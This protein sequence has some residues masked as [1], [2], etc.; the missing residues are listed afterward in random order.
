MS[1][2]VLRLGLLLCMCL[3][4]LLGAVP[5][6]AQPAGIEVQS[7]VDHEVVSVGDTVQ[8]TLQVMSTGSGRE[9]E[10]PQ[11][12]TTQGFTVVGQRASPSTS[13]SII[14]GVRS[15]KT[16]LSVTWV[17]RAEREG[18][19]TL[20]P[21][22]V[23]SHG[24]R[25]SGTVLS[26]RV[27]RRGAA[28]GPKRPGPGWPFA[29]GADP[30]KGIF[31]DEPQDPQLLLGEPSTDPALSLDAPRG[32]GSFFHA[33]V[34]KTRALVGEQVTLKI[35]TYTD[36]STQEPDYTDLHE[37]PAADFVKHLLPHDRS[38][39]G[40][41]KI[42]GKIY[43]VGLVRRYA[44]FPLKAGALEIGPMTGVAM[45]G[46][47]KTSVE[48]ERIVIQA[49]E[50]PAAGRPAGYALGDVGD[51]KLR[52][53]VEPRQT[54]V[55]GA[56]QVTVDL[57]GEG[58]L[59]S[60]LPLPTPP[61]IEFL[62]PETHERIG[63]ARGDRLG[64]TRSFSYV[65]RAQRPGT[66]DLGII[67]LPFYDVE[68]R[69]YRNAQAVL[70]TITVTGVAP[71]EAPKADGAP[72]MPA[73]REQPEPRIAPRYLSDSPWFLWG[74]AVWPF[75]LAL[76]RAGQTARARLRARAQSKADSP[77]H[78]LEL[79]RVEAER[80]LRGS[81]GQASLRAVHEFVLA[82]C[83]TRLGINARALTAN[84]LQEAL[85]GT[86]LAAADQ[87]A[88]GTLLAECESLRFLPSGVEPEAAKE[89]WQRAQKLD[90]ALR[91]AGGR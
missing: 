74:I 67:N 84:E 18:N 89:L 57:S 47:R 58:N 61:G 37:S 48:S 52:A 51:F 2:A 6:S 43:A 8:L 16:G 91:K 11:P 7:G 55:G 21:P 72:S 41:A 39:V 3:G 31:D 35:Y 13:I 42:Q 85:G 78:A 28:N 46:R 12:G 69:A 10:D 15:Q 60:Q 80:S 86:A 34:D 38:L 33:Q 81:D 20:G 66:I 9:F 40:H 68:R 79:R 24:R 83:S 82:A 30:F 53:D 17:L 59:P 36:I 23:R 71:A 87:Q 63:V 70:G 75:G 29:P 62:P 5:A 90:V 22:S 88:L 73:P 77:E 64:G 26:V 49:Q 32:D 65:V 76:F 25:I 27:Q 4:A 50:P 45:R 56:V 44:L 1:R 19:L 54:E 14:N